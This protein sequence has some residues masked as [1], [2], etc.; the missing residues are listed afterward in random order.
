MYQASLE[1]I[2]ST[3]KEKRK[4]GRER[5]ERKKQKDMKLTRSAFFLNLFI[6][7]NCLSLVLTISL[8][9]TFEAFLAF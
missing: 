5:K 1:K 9:G 6:T 7:E 3:E 8:N 2:T 4:M